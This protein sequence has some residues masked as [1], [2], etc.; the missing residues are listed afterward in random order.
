MISGCASERGPTQCEEGWC[1]CAGGYCANAEG[2]C[3][4]YAGEWLGDHALAFTN[5]YQPAKPYVQA[6][7]LSDS[8]FDEKGDLAQQAGVSHTLA[9]SAD[10]GKYWKVA[11][12]GHGHV[13]F[14][15]NAAPG[16]IMSI[17]H[18]RRR[19][20]E[21]QGGRR[22][23]FMQLRKKRGGAAPAHLDVHAEDPH[24]SEKA[25][26]RLRFGEHPLQPETLAGFMASNSTAGRVHISDDDELWPV[27]LRFSQAHPL[28]ASFRVRQTMKD[29][30]GVEIWDPDMQVA[31]SSASPDWTFADRVADQGVAEC[32]APGLFISGDCE[33]RQHVRFEPPLPTKAI[34]TGP[35]DEIFE[36]GTVS[37]FEMLIIFALIGACVLLI[38]YVTQEIKSRFAN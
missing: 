2:K 6:Q 29:G 13:R 33:G 24:E 8:W 17:Y 34:V 1:M 9:A 32:S 25:Q 3:D 28:D 35:R 26:A 11:L 23:S 15:S 12:T 7:P 20:S 31:L 18:V 37:F 16:H 10:P 5:S 21:E 19:R 22:R 27:L 38:L 30:G 4:Q 14:E 36:V